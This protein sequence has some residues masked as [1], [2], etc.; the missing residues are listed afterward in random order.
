M[1][2]GGAEIFASTGTVSASVGTQ[3]LTRGNRCGA[4][5][6]ICAQE[7]IGVRSTTLGWVSLKKEGKLGLTVVEKR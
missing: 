5:K 3:S 1:V 4:A 6:T 2:R 7:I